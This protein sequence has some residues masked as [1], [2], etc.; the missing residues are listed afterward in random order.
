MH[1]ET[2]GTI[3]RNSTGQPPIQPKRGLTMKHFDTMGFPG[4]AEDCCQQ[5]FKEGIIKPLDDEA[6]AF[7]G[8][9]E[10]IVEEKLIMEDLPEADEIQPLAN[11]PSLTVD[12]VVAKLKDLND[13]QVKDVFIYE[14][15]K[16]GK[17]RKGVVEACN[18]RLA[19]PE[20]ADE[21]AEGE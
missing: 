19:P 10:L 11:Y 9:I 13:R 8:I 15:G 20:D 4:D 6:K 2:I 12:Q 5:L 21:S 17:S 14:T 7:L 3:L 1:F 18:K 16:K